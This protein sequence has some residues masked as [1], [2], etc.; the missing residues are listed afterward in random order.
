[1][2]PPR[3]QTGDMKTAAGWYS[4][5]D[6]QITALQRE[7]R[8]GLQAQDVIHDV[9]RCISRQP[10]QPVLPAISLARF[11]LDMHPIKEDPMARSADNIGSACS[12]I[13]S[14]G[15]PRLNS[16]AAFKSMS[17]DMDSGSPGSARRTR[18]GSG[19]RKSL[20]LQS[21]AS[22]RPAMKRKSASMEAVG[23]GEGFDATGVQPTLSMRLTRSVDHQST[24]C[25]GLQFGSSM[26][27]SPSSSTYSLMDA[28][29]AM[30][31]ISAA[32]SA[33]QQKLSGG[34]VNQASPSDDRLDDLLRELIISS[35]SGSA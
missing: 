4:E 27:C 5:S 24:S 35:G 32:A 11:E 13:G 20:H 18:V 25:G 21:T 23:A 16:I 7:S 14:Q 9:D 26:L 1:M 19:A 28:D 2:Q 33:E 34:R 10:E 15:C 31:I 3:R 6:L 22:N 30:S 29:S 12:S 17:V 8:P